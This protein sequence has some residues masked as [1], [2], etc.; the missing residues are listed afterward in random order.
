MSHTS[1]AASAPSQPR[2]TLRADFTAYT[3]RHATTAKRR[4]DAKQQLR[5]FFK[6]PFSMKS[7]TFL[8]SAP[9]AAL[10]V[11]IVATTSVS[12]YALTNWF[13]A[14]VTVKQNNSVL[15]VD[16]SQC[17]GSLPPG[18]EPS[19]DKSNIQFKILGTS[20]IS[21]EQLQRQ[22]LAECE[23]NAV[24]DFYHNNSE[25]QSYSLYPST[26][27]EI[28][29]D[30]TITLDYFWGGQ[31][32]EKT[33]EAPKAASI[34]D[35]GNKIGL[36]GLKAG[37]TVVF[38]AETPRVIEGSDPLAAVGEVKSIFKTQ[39]DTREAPEASKK[40]FYEE[41]NIMP[42]GMYEQLHQ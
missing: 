21:T 19:A 6:E 32:I 17:K 11:A 14:N 18:I 24:V 35:Q 29:A 30:G 1:H 25:G 36:Q 5:A 13:N 28:N 31:T 41:S 16:L 7:L 9:G 33:F 4:A 26:V 34:Y 10:A 38:A 27:K 42:L 3:M 2:R 20:H 22:L 40:A 37:D 8:R 39:Y 23:Y 12:A 15:S